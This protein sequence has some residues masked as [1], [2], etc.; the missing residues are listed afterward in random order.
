MC[1]RG[2]WNYRAITRLRTTGLRT[3]ARLRTTTTVGSTIVTA[4]PAEDVASAPGAAI[5][6]AAYVCELTTASTAI[7]A[8]A[9]SI[10]YINFIVSTRSKVA[11]RS[12][13]VRAV[14]SM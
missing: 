4:L 14:R 11:R 6:P 1:L 9:K 8:A 3:T 5:G 13:A 12:Y 2:G 7:R 10:M